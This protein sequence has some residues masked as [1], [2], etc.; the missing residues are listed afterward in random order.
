M[1]HNGSCLCGL[2]KYEME[3]D[4]DHFFLCH[5]SRCRKDSGSAH[6]ANLFS[7]KGKLVWLS[8]ESSVKTFSLPDGHTHAF[9]SNCGSKLPFVGADKAVVVPAGSLD[10]IL[11]MQPDAHIFYQSRAKWDNTLEKITKFDE[12]PVVN[13]DSK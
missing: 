12:L 6:G 4:F 1:R 2:V 11:D 10:T 8:G 5:C 9:C 3:G 7:V 13:A